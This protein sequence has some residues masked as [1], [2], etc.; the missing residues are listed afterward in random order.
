MSAPAPLLQ[1]KLGT[2]DLTLLHD[3][4]FR[5]DGGA[6]FGTV[7]KVL[8]ERKKPAD[9]ANRIT[10]VTHCPLLRRGDDLVLID[11][12]IGDKNDAKFRSI[13]GMADDAERLPAA[14][15]R[16]GYEPE[17]VTH[18]VL[19]HLHFD[20]CGW[21]TRAAGDR[22]VPTFPKARYWIERGEIEHARHP[23]PR[24]RA[25]YDPRNWEPL[26]EAGLVELF[27]GRG[28]PV[29]G[30][31]ALRAPGHNDSMCVVRIDGREAAGTGAG[32]ALFLTDLVPTAAHVPYPW[33]MGYDLYPVTTI[34][35]KRK[36]LPRAADEGWLVIFEHD[37]EVPLAR[38]VADGKN[39]YRAEP[40][41]SQG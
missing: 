4:E 8:W 29:P 17:D 6:M 37:P 39:R 15:R 38:L 1:R 2:F 19:S 21:N 30:I 3:G 25:S 23:N 41:V 27:D 7:P 32:Q 24:D 36:W 34:E 12:G 28:E 11:T 20:H 35:N 13:F 40:V 16:A 10:M 31:E 22:Y 14:L 18:V 33:V 26:F 5:L 9:E